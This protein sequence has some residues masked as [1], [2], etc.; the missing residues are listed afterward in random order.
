MSKKKY[1]ASG[2]AMFLGKGGEGVDREHERKG[3]DLRA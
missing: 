2:N 1:R 3:Y